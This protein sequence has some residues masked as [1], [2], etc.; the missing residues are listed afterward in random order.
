MVHE[1]DDQ[2]AFLEECKHR[3]KFDGAGDKLHS[4]NVQW[5]AKFMSG[6]YRAVS[7]NLSLNAAWYSPHRNLLQ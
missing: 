7:F 3:E 5:L 2:L 4:S 6:V 1:S